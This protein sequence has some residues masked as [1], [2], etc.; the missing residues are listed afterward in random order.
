MIDTSAALSDSDWIAIAKGS[1][2]AEITTLVP[3]AP[4]HIAL[5]LIAMLRAKHLDARRTYDRQ[6]FAAHG[7]R[8]LMRR[9]VLLARLDRNL[10]EQARL[11]NELE[12]A[13]RGKLS[14]ELSFAE[15][16]DALER[17][18]P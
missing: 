9:R 7:A 6:R 12:S 14:L 4:K 15:I 17:V 18:T 8:D 13:V 2:I 10:A 16:C 3:L 11:L 5:E 1:T